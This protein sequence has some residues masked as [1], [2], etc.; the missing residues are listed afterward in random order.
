MTCHGCRRT[1]A[2]PTAAL[3]LT[4][5]AGPVTAL[6][7]Q[8][9]PACAALLDLDAESLVSRSAHWLQNAAPRWVAGRATALLEQAQGSEAP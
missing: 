9:C 7:L 2:R 4:V 5:T 8:I 1:I 6:A 3:T